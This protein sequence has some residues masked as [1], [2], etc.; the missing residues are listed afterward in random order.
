[1]ME[2]QQVKADKL[3]LSNTLLLHIYK[4]ITLNKTTLQIKK[5]YKK[6][7]EPITDQAILFQNPS[8]KYPHLQHPQP[9]IT[10]STNQPRKHQGM[11][12]NR[13]GKSAQEQ[14]SPTRKSL[15]LNAVSVNRDTSVD[16]NE[17][18]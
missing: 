8:R 15:N 13:R 12:L 14:L 4:T 2:F 1:M 10:L 11:V 6:C 3:L 9:P 17:R 5:N 18:I 7:L 16:Q